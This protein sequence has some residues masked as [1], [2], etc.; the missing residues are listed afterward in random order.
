MNTLEENN[1]VG[2][3]YNKEIDIIVPGENV[4]EK[5]I[6]RTY[7]G[8]AINFTPNKTGSQARIFS[9]FFPPL[10][11]ALY[12]EDSAFPAN[13]KLKIL[14]A[15][16]VNGANELKETSFSINYQFTF[17]SYGNY[18]LNFYIYFNKSATA[19]VGNS[20]KSFPFEV[21]FTGSHVLP[22][23][24]TKIPL[25]SIKTIQ[26]FM[27]DVDPETTRGTVTVVQ[28]TTG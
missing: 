25:G 22:V 27:V 11:A 13:N 9:K 10:A 1:S 12:Y 7:P 2:A 8:N 28:D 3:I 15:A 23:D 19:V 6:N 24:G 16:I 4:P 14:M 21:T 20:Y 17:N 18:Q 26:V 5:N